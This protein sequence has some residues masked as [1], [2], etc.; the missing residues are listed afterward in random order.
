[1]RK[2]M[3]KIDLQN[4]L[5]AMMPK[6]TFP[7]CNQQPYMV[8]EE[9]SPLLWF[10]EPSNRK[11]V[12]PNG[13]PSPGGP[14]TATNGRALE[15]NHTGLCYYHAKKEYDLFDQKYP[16]KGIKRNSLL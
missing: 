14:L 6:C 15:P 12:E 11:Y 10:K 9:N 13:S 5:A 2:R 4:A 1:M 8:P 16:L 3:S 7:C